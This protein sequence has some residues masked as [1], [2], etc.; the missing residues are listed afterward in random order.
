MKSYAA[1]LLLSVTSMAALTACESGRPVPGLSICPEVAIVP[2]GGNQQFQLCNEGVA[3][4]LV[5]WSTPG[6]G[7]I[8]QGRYHAP[9]L[10]RAPQRVIIRATVGPKNEVLSGRAV[11]LLTAGSVPG[12]DSCAGPAQ[13]ELPERGEYVYVDELPEAIHTVAPIYPDSA[14]AHGVE[15]TVLVEVLV[16]ASGNVIDSHVVSSIPEL[17][18]ASEHAARQWVFQPAMIG[19]LPVAVWV[20]IPFRFV[21]HAARTA[22]R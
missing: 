15:G 14:L 9:L 22:S 16:C 1:I 12:A 21:L 2:P 10:V 8:S 13:S 4:S 5:R 6:P 11:V 19:G 20:A 18:D 7:R 3:D 17:D